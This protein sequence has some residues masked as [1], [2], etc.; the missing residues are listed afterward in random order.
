MIG[1]FADGTQNTSGEWRRNRQQNK[2][3]CRNNVE[4]KSYCSQGK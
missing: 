1:F 2:R 4:Q 3:K